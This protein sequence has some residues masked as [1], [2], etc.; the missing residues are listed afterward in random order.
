MLIL[1]VVELQ[2]EYDIGNVRHIRAF[3]IQPDTELDKEFILE[4]W[5]RTQDVF[6]DRWGDETILKTEKLILCISAEA[7]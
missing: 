6:T 4:D 1:I 3:Q 5:K 2:K 7:L